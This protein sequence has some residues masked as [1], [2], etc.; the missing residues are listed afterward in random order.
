M[1]S[2]PVDN[3][4]RLYDL[5]DQAV[6][7]ADTPRPA[8]RAKRRVVIWFTT[9]HIRIGERVWDAHREDRDGFGYTLA[10]AREMREALLPVMA[11]AAPAAEAAVRALLNE[12]EGPAQ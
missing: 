11:A 9:A 3:P 10:Q 7:D 2:I 4:A 1:G 12:L 6:T 5:L 8:W